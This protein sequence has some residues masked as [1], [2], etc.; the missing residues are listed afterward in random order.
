M[1]K[2]PVDPAIYHITHVDNL[3]SI[4]ASAG[5]LSDA[6]RRQGRFTARNIGYLHIKNRRMARQVCR[7][8]GDAVAAGGVLGDY[9]PFNFCFRSVMLHR[10]SIGH[11]DHSGGDGEVV[12]LLSTVQGAVRAGRPFAFTD[13]HA[14]LAY[15][16]YFDDL[17]DLVHVPWE[18]MPLTYWPHV[19]EQRQAEFLVHEF[20]PWTGV[21]RIVAKSQAVAARVSSTLAAA[22]ASHLP[23]VAVNPQW[24]Y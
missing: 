15:A 22:G 6:A 13:R 10:V 14:E 18:V 17:S 8:S 19:R 2:V 9:V 7:V 1:T 12:H 4:L 5:L 21:T 20:F 11:R 24:Y 16:E 3:P 23:A